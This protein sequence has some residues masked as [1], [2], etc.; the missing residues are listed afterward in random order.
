MTD[1][2]DKDKAREEAERKAEE[3]NLRV[4]VVQKICPKVTPTQADH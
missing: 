4:D 1:A 3:D 2:I